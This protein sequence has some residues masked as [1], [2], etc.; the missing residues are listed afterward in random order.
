[1]GTSKS[2]GFSWLDRL[3]K[4]DDKH[5]EKREKLRNLVG[6]DEFPEEFPK[7]LEDVPDGL[8]FWLEMYVFHQLRSSRN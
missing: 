7:Y 8:E 4:Q 3:N 2:R 6:T 1:M 5:I